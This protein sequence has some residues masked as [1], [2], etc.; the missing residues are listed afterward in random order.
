M[1]KSLL[2]VSVL[3]ISALPAFSQD[4]PSKKIIV[5][6]FYGGP[7]LISSI[8]TADVNTSGYSSST[9]VRGFGPIGAR[10]DYLVSKNLSLG[11]EVHHATS[12]IEREVTT[13][14]NGTT[15]VFKDKLSVNRTRIYPRLAAH[16]GKGNLDA[17]WFLA[18]GFALWN[19]DYSVETNSNASQ[20]TGIS[21]LDLNRNSTEFAFRTGLGVRYFFT[22]TFGFHADLGIGGPFFT[23][24]LSSRF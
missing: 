1:K 22:E 24:G 11:L 3:I 17:Y 18:T 6:V 20:F 19:S 9:K 12:A 16:F 2:L 23:F 4:E 8:V 7:N 14:S 13:T 10:V 5:D 15:E 21:I